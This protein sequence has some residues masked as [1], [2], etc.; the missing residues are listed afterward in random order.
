MYKYLVANGNLRE[1]VLTVSSIKQQNSLLDSEQ[2]PWPSTRAKQRDSIKTAPFGKGHPVLWSQA[3]VSQ[4]EGFSLL[5]TLGGTAWDQSWL[6][7]LWPGH[8]FAT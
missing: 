6:V 3:S 2:T 7:H 5:E 4:V 1:N 8:D